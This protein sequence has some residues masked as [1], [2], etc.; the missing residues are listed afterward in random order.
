A[1]PQPAAFD[2]RM[3][4]VLNQELPLSVWYTLTQD[5]R[6]SPRQHNE[7][8]A[9]TWM[10]ALLLGNDDTALQLAPMMQTSYPSLKSLVS[11]FQTPRTPSERRF[12]ACYAMLKAPGL[13]PY[14]RGGLGRSTS[15]VK[16]RDDYGDNF[17][18][19]SNPDEK[20]KDP[21]TPV[22][23]TGDSDPALLK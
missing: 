2:E 6:L 20:K 21:E 18:I 17:W 15:D 13:S 1:E 12:A 9:S 22:Y 7:V 5:K 3:V 11:S 23:E 16:E 19:P 4:D 10:R 14:L 8:V